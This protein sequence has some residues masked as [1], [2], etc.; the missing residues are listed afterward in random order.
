MSEFFE[1][2]VLSPRNN[3]VFSKETS[4]K[5]LLETLDLITQSV[6]EGFA[7]DVIYLDF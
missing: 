4:V 1:K 5:N 6:S 2:K 3:M 7:V